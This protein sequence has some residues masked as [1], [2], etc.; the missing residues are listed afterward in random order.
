M[1]LDNSQKQQLPPSQL[2]TP[3]L[4]ALS[5]NQRVKFET[6]LSPGQFSSWEIRGVNANCD[7]IS[8]FDSARG[9]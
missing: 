4:L 3:I 1:S 5:Q 2:L 6:S 7:S 9:G 8:L